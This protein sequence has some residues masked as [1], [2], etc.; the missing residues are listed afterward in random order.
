MPDEDGSESTNRDAYL[1]NCTQ[2]RTSGQD[3]QQVLEA[4]FRDL[5]MLQTRIDGETFFAAGVPWFV[6]IFGRDTLMTALETLAYNP[7]IAEQTLLLMAK[8][9]GQGEDEWTEE[10]PGKILHELRQDELTNIGEV[11]YRPYYG[12]VDATVLFLLLCARHA[13]WTG[14]LDLFERL[15]SNVMAALGGSTS[16][17]IRTA[18]AIWTTPSTCPPA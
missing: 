5:R 18:T 8:Y 14:R 15:Q 10:Q 3:A 17:A 12:T 7:L 11:P 13:R 4:S 9:Q 2:V 16:T 1:R 6:T